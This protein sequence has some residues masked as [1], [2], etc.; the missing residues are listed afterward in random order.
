MHP[1]CSASSSFRS[2]CY[3]RTEYW[4]WTAI[5]TGLKPRSS[6]AS[7]LHQPRQMYTPTRGAG[8]TRRI[9]HLYSPVFGRKQRAGVEE[10]VDSPVEY[11]DWL[12]R[13]RY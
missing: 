12:V 3:Q 2:T 7:L 1:N 10:V 11:R 8:N 9:Y 4:R 13:G 5:R 6:A